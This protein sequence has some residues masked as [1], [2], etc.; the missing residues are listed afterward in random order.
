[1]Q[2]MLA[3]ESLTPAEAA[4]VNLDVAQTEVVEEAV[5]EADEEGALGNVEQLLHPKVGFPRA[6]PLPSRPPASPTPSPHTH[7]HPDALHPHHSASTHAPTSNP[8]LPLSS[9]LSSSLCRLAL[10]SLPPIYVWPWN[11]RNCCNCR[12]C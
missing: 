12:S 8:S 6:T 9:S 11:C 2:S 3:K 5:V 1:M 4:A 7:H 10:P